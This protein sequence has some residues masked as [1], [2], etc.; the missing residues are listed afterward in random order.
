VS[1]DWEQAEF[2]LY[3]EWDAALTHLF[4]QVSAS[5]DIA[6]RKPASADDGVEVK[7]YR[8]RVGQDLKAFHEKLSNIMES[9][10]SGQ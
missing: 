1:P 5:R 7:S 4:G 10:K 3:Q 8:D 9:E 2:H 6:S